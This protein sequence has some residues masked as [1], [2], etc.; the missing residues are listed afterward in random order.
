[1]L[2]VNSLIGRNYH[3][4]IAIFFWLNEKKTLFRGEMFRGHSADI[5]YPTNI[6]YMSKDI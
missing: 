5:L 1:M 6:R 4:D 3:D 2:Q